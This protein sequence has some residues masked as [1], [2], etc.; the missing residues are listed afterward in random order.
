[1]S[2]PDDPSPIVIA[3]PKSLVTGPPSAAVPS[4]VCPV[5]TAKAE[6]N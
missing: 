6:T 1:M 5:E 2:V 3:V 4:W